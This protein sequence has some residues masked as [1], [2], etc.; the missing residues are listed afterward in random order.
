MKK[1][2]DF[3][4]EW[5][6]IILLMGI[7]VLIP[8]FIIKSS[9][10]LINKHTSKDLL[11]AFSNGTELKCSTNPLGGEVYVVSNKNGWKIYKKQYLKKGDLIV[12]IVNCMRFD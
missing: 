12:D 5:F 2:V 4:F 9:S 6:M 7:I 1:L 3:L 8:V 10:D 11:K